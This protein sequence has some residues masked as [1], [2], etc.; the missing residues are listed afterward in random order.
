[1]KKIE[2]A[3][4]RDEIFNTFFGGRYIILL[5]GMFSM[6]TGLIYNDIYSR[7]INIFGSSWQNPYCFDSLLTW[8]EIEYGSTNNEKYLVDLPPKEAF[9]H[10]KGPYP[11]GVDPVWN[12]AENKLNFLNAM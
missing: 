2:R 5:M 11:F 4:I 7:S 8:A 3:K 6:Y 10:D 1:E 9:R 12:V